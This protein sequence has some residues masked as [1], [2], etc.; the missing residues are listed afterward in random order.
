MSLSAFAFAAMALPKLASR[1]LNVIL[2][3][4]YA[5]IHALSH[6]SSSSSS[7][8]AAASSSFEWWQLAAPSH[9]AT[10]LLCA[11]LLI[12]SAWQPKYLRHV[13]HVNF[14]GYCLQS[15]FM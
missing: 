14:G 13:V 1:S 8:A 7:A 5:L 3:L 10:A 2:P 9:Y 4:M 15:A 11:L 6:M 12:A